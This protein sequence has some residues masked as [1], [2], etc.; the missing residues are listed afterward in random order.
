MLQQA[1]VSDVR[2]PSDPMLSAMSKDDKYGGNPC[3]CGTLIHARNERHG[4]KAD[5]V[6]TRHSA[7]PDNLHVDRLPPWHRGRH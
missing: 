5:G 6:L 2:E 4:S 7:H 1:S 3:T